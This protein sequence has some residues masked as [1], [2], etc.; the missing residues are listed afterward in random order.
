MRSYLKSRKH[1]K[2][3]MNVDYVLSNQLHDQDTRTD[4]KTTN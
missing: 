1:L 3:F 4:H 2:Y